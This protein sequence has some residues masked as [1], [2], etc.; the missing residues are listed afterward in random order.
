METENHLDSQKALAW[1]EGDEKMLLRLK[2]LFVK[3]VPPQMERLK[4]HLATGDLAEAERLA[5]TINGS[6]AMIGATRM[7]ESAKKVER[8]LIDGDLS[9]ATALFAQ[10]ESEFRLVL[11]E[12]NR[13]GV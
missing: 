4:T 11:G 10:M 12:L 1:L 7:S 9:G 5:H 13:A 8:S 2:A 6:T 3:N